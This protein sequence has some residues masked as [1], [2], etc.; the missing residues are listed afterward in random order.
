MPVLKNYPIRLNRD[1]DVRRLKPTDM[2]Y[3]LNVNTSKSTGRDEGV[4]ENVKGTTE[5]TNS[6]LPAGTNKCVGVIPHEQSNNLFYFIW[7]SNNNHGI[8]YV[9]DI[10]GNVRQVLESSVLNFNKNGFIVGE[11]YQ[12][13]SSE[14]I[15]L[16]F[17]DNINPPR[18]VNVQKAI[19]NRYSTVNEEVIQ[20]IK[21]APSSEPTWNYTADDSVI[22]NN[23][24][25]KNYQFRCRYLYDDGEYSAYS[26]HSSL[27]YNDKQLLAS[28]KDSVDPYSDLNN[29]E[30][31]V[32]T[33][34]ELVRKIEVIA[35]RGDDAEWRV[36]KTLRNTTSESTITFDFKDDGSYPVA[37]PI[38]TNK[39]FD[40]VPL[41]AEAIAIVNS[42]IFLGNY[43]DGF[44]PN[45]DIEQIT[46]N[47]DEITLAARSEN[48]DIP[49]FTDATFSSSRLNRE[50]YQIT[51]DYSG[52]TPNEGDLFILN[53]YTSV[54]IYT[55]TGAQYQRRVITPN[56]F[57]S[58][59]VQNGDTLADVITAL[60]EGLVG[61]SRL[62]NNLRR[63]TS[64]NSTQ[65]VIRY[66]FERLE[67][68]NEQIGFDSGGGEEINN[69]SNSGKY[70]PMTGAQS[71]KKGSKYSLGIIEYDEAG[72]AST[73]NVFPNNEVY[74]PF[75]SEEEPNTNDMLGKMSIDYRISNSVKPS[76]RATKWSW[77]ITENTSIGDFVQYSALGAFGVANIDYPNDDTVYISLRGLQSQN[78]SYVTAYDAVP[79]TYNYQDGD[80]LRIISYIDDVNGTPTRVI[81]DGNLDFR[82]TSGRVY[83]EDD[84]PIY[85]GG[86]TPSAIQR[87]T[88]YILGLQPI[89]ESGWDTASTSF[90]NKVTD[91]DATNEGAVI[92]EIYRP[93]PQTEDTDLVY[94][95]VGGIQDV[96]NAGTSSRNF[97]GSLRSQGDAKSYS[98]T[99]QAGNSVTVSSSSVDLVIND[100]VSLKD[101]GGT[102]IDTGT[103]YDIQPSGGNVILFIRFNSETSSTIDSVELLDTVAAGVLTEGDVWIKPRLI[104]DDNFVNAQTY[105]L[106]PVEDY[107]L[108]D[109]TPSANW[110]K[111]RANAFSENAKEVRRFSTVTYSEP[112]FNETNVN[113][114]SSFNLGLSNFQQYNQ[115]YGPIRRLYSNDIYL[116]CFQENKIGRIPISRRVISTAT[117]DN[118]LTL[119]EDILNDI[120]YYKGDYGL[121]KPESFVAYDG[122]FYG[123]DIKKAK[124][125]ELGA[126]GIQL[127]SDY[128]LSSYIEEQSKELLPYYNNARL[129]IGLDREFDSVYISSLSS[130]A[131]QA[132]SDGSNTT[133][134]DF[135]E[136]ADDGTNLVVKALP[137]KTNSDVS[138]NRLSVESRALSDIPTALPSLGGLQQN[139]NLVPETG[140]FEYSGPIKT[141]GTEAVT[142]KVNLGGTERFAT[143]EY[144]F[145]ASE[146]KI[147]KTQSGFSLALAGSPTVYSGF[148]LGYN[149]SYNIWTSFYSFIPEMYGNIN[150]SCY[151][152][153]EGVLYKHN[154]NSNYNTFYGTSYDTVFEVNFNQEPSRVKI[155][156]AT[157]IEGNKGNFSVTLNSNLNSSSI[158]STYFSEKEGFYQAMIPRSSTSSN[159]SDIIGGGTGTYSGSNLTITGIDVYDIGVTVGDTVYNSSGVSV[160]TVTAIVNSNTITVSGGSGSGFFY[161]GKTSTVIEGDR[162]RG[163]YLTARYTN[164]DTTFTEVFAVN[165]EVT[166]SRLHNT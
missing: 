113:G 54:P 152:F 40:N 105:S 78:S 94:Y 90:W 55:I 88:G 108:S 12:G 49:V 116:V 86:G 147:P 67:G 122:D 160:G 64:I 131:K 87:R 101:S 106:F 98:V 134:E 139:L 15:L 61:T 148:T 118:S 34:S 7:N 85:N 29:I 20:L 8:Y 71:F 129:V 9:N 133:I 23:V 130:V 35:R 45:P 68:N 19:E 4:L 80:R 25:N 151:S 137:E 41:Q 75:Y 140:T 70:P 22:Y 36:I 74:I 5:I 39:Y 82:I 66:V 93:K 73:V 138:V 26:A 89:T 3:A 166:N 121:T 59:Q 161:I 142:F 91:T 150:Y 120:D 50:Q 57:E 17:T 84:S 10:T 24:Y 37:D 92:F 119:S 72:R 48:Y 126:A 95:E 14:E 104:R 109:F 11:A 144:D 83:G 32:P 1:D 164:S 56:I 96:N 77:C 38:E 117:G 62:Q 146:I 132:I 112:Y 157:S 21:Y 6:D 13:R 153:K 110:G 42:R 125:W 111:G 47:V 128:K 127:V 136:L 33:G 102:E 154:T 141:S 107:N 145:S 149:K 63:E 99:A 165:A 155:Y 58:Y 114:F 100:V 79:I 27:S 158:P 81:A 159:F 76:L 123:W 103:I 44:D 30:V 18:K 51:I 115:S 43:I 31:T 2:T 53:Q 124:I 162:I 135:A 143:G 16:Y 28:V 69:V 46:S 60:T 156:D 97:A 163:Y 65:V 52:I